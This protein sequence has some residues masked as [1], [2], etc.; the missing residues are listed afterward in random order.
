MLQPFIRIIALLVLVSSLF[1]F[2]GVSRACLL[3][4]NPAAAADDCCPADHQSSDKSDD[5]ST[6]LECPCCAACAGAN[7]YTTVPAPKR[8]VTTS[9]HPRHLFPIPPTG[10]LSSIDYPPESA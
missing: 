3:M 8:V 6:L 5:M 7:I 2:S 10:F 1:C 9:S 4:A